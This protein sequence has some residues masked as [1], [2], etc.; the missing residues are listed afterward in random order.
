MA[1]AVRASRFTALVLL[2]TSVVAAAD[3]VEPAPAAYA[4][5]F[6]ETCRSGFPDLDAI[7]K[8]A[9]A[10]GW[11]ERSVS[12]VAMIGS[13][14][15]AL[16]HSFSKDGLMLFLTRGAT[17]FSVVCQVTGTAETRFSGSDVASL[18][19]P[20]LN[21]GN[22]SPGRGDDKKDELTVWDLGQGVSVEA[23]VNVYQRRARSVSIAIRQAFPAGAEPRDEARVA[24]SNDIS[25]VAIGLPFTPEEPTPVDA[26]HPLFHDVAIGDIQGLPATVKSSS[27]NFIA[28]AKR[29]SI[30]AALRETFR[31]MNLLAP[32]PVAGRKRL[33]VTWRG[34]HTPFH[35]GTNNATSVTLHYRLERGD[36][37][38]N[39]F[40]REITTSARGGGANASMRD[41]GIV[42]AA[43]AA[44]FASA[45][46]CLDRA[47]FGTA[48]ADCALTP[49]FSV[50]IERIDR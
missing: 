42:R 12:S 30:N 27:L 14:R 2:C 1:F 21:A 36:T 17:A 41:N 9:A 49:Q 44:N 50:S 37:G 19:G 26:S 20:G 18:V 23:G 40:D 3:P 7:A 13:N 29:S 4:Q 10:R 45:A 6:N 47:A 8:V 32:D 46:N 38:R 28:A 22:G 15:I 35:I 16:P 39:L 25:M 33:V 5:A 34:D 24:P 48:P 11:T 43:I 31:R